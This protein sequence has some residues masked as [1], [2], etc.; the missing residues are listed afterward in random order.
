M[1][2]IGVAAV[3]V[4]LL[5]VIATRPERYHLERSTTI[6]APPEV[7]FAQVNDFHAWTAWSPWEKVDPELK[8]SYD[9]PA[10]GVGAHYAWSG[11]AKAGAGNMTILSSQQPTHVEIT[12]QFL[13]PFKNVAQATFTFVPSAGGTRVTWAM[14]GKNNFLGKAFSLVANMDK[15]VGGEFEKGLAAMQTVCEGRSVNVQ[16]PA[17]GGSLANN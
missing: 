16:R 9:G 1:I 14:D 7:V 10:Q 11:N 4:L 17:G 12:I 5:V 15:L 6:G 8:R 3:I 2:F 13:K